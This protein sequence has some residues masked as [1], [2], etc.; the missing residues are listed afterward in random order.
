MRSAHMKALKRGYQIYIHTLREAICFKRQLS[1]VDLCAL[2]KG[3]LSKVATFEE[4]MP[5]AQM[6]RTANVGLLRC[7]ALIRRQLSQVA[8]EKCENSP[9]RSL[10][11]LTQLHSLTHTG[12]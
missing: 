10:T 5:F 1:H 3:T 12:Q 11:V 6:L 7:S 4:Y 8:A 2:L 9:N